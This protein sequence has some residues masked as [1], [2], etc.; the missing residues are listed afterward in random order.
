MRAVLDANIYV[1]ALI[2][3]EGPPGRILRRFVDQHDFELIVSPS[4]LRE[5]EVVLF[6]PK[7]RKYLKAGPD[8]V[9]SWVLSIGMLATIVRGNLAVN[10]VTGDPADNKYIAAALEG[11]A[12]YIVSGDH[13]LLQIGEHQG[14]WILPPS[15]FL[16]ILK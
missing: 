8:E 15:P 10:V 5:I 14:I 12:H 7:I 9:K 11:S 16:K 13:H 1:S 6:Y 2:C 3:P 4:I